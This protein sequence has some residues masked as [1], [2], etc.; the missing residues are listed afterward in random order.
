MIRPSLISSISPLLQ[1]GFWPN[2]VPTESYDKG[3]SNGASCKVFGVELTEEVGFYRMINQSDLIRIINAFH[4]R[5][6][7][8]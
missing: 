8:H 5:L 1:Y 6:C 2:L 4:F 7:L 3:E